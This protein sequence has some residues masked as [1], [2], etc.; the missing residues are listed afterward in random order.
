MTLK[1]ICFLSPGT[2]PTCSEP[3]AKNKCTV[4]KRTVDMCFI[5]RLNQVGLSE[6]QT[7]FMPHI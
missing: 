3:A 1:L 6:L 2:L 7:T 5:M 4:H